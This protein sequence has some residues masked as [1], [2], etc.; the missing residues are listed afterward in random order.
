VYWP[1]IGYPV[2]MHQR[3]RRRFRSRLAQIGFALLAL[4]ILLR[5]VL[6]AVGEIHELAHDAS[7]HHSTLV[8]N[9]GPIGAGT[10]LAETEEMGALD[11]LMHF[12]HC[13]GQVSALDSA[14][15]LAAFHPAPFARVH[16]ACAARV[17]HARWQT[18]FRPPIAA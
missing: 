18:P 1:R 6:A 12:A 10:S 8:V 14:I 11:A 2:G 15:S 3:S 4:S 16:E 13:C 9:G 5:P 17:T 7:G